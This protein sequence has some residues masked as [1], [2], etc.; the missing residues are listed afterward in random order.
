MFYN[1]FSLD[2][3]TEKAKEIVNIA[4][5]VH[6]NSACVGDY[7]VRDADI[8]DRGIF[9]TENTDLD[10]FE[11]ALE[12]VICV[13]AITDEKFD[14]YSIEALIIDADE[15][16]L[17]VKSAIVLCTNERK[18]IKELYEECDSKDEFAEK[19]SSALEEC[20]EAPEQ[21][22]KEYCV[23]NGIE[24][25]DDADVSDFPEDMDGLEK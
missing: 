24:W 18:V 17:T 25:I 11:E 22:F 2:K 7:T 10:S 9:C 20:N 12:N 15:D 4:E 3:D 1:V 13:T 19:A 8:D 16:K 5:K 14:E 21:D 6:I 23:N